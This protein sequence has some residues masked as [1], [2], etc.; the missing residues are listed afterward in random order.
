MGARNNN[1]ENIVRGLY[2]GRV[3]KMTKAQERRREHM[4]CGKRVLDRGKTALESIN[5]GLL[6]EP[7]WTIPEMRCEV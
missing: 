4:G 6:R 1:S 3:R 5:G 2:R 7:R